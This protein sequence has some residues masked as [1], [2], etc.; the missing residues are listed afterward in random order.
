MT[1]FRNKVAL[2]TGASRGIGAGVARLLAE[3]GVDVVI[4]YRSKGPRAEEVAAAI[5]AVGRRALLAQA[6]VTQEGDLQAMKRAVTSSFP[7]L[8]IL[9]LNAS[10]GLEKDKSTEYAM[11]LNRDAQVRAVEVF[12]P[13]MPPGGCIV[14]VTSHWA[15][16]YGQKPVHRVYEI[17]AVSKRAGED[18]LRARIP[19]LSARGIRLIIASGDMVEGTITPKL[20]ERAQRG[21]LTERRHQVGRLPTVEEFAEAIVNGIQDANIRSGDVIFVGSTD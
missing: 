6:D 8:D 1:D 17:V 10:G 4:N 14:F 9:V 20:L 11:Q 19:E 12:A 21:L 18:A 2:I 13:V 3:R 16:F 15:H 7:Q 5:R